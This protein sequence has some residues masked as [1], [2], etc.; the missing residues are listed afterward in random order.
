M[1]ERL[2]ITVPE[3]AEILG[4]N[5]TGAYRAIERGELPAIRIGRRLVVPKA[6]IARLLEGGGMPAPAPGDDA[7]PAKPLRRVSQ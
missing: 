1:A 6:A 5:R 2:T 7:A 4:I 3:A